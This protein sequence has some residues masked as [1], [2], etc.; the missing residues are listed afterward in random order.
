MK[1]F[2][3]S[4]IIFLILLTLITVN[5]FYVHNVCDKMIELTFS[6]S[7]SNTDN[8]NQLYM[9]W[10]KNEATFSISIHDAHIEKI[11]ELIENIKS[12]VT[13]GNGAELEKNITLL[14]EI[15]NEL[16]KNEEISFQ[17]I[18]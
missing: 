9:L 2:I 14:R 12:A 18:I 17:S 4:I 11:S 10:K 8:A 6:I 5:I 3:I 13:V 1:S 7:E 15:L 16:K